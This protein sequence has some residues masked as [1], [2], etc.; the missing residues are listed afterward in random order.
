MWIIEGTTQRQRIIN[1][2][3]TL[4]SNS[5]GRFQQ[6]KLNNDLANVKNQY[7]QLLTELGK[8]AWEQQ[9]IHPSYVHMFEILGNFFQERTRLQSEL[10]A[11][12]TQLQRQNNQHTQI[13]ADYA[14][15]IKAV[16]DQQKITNNRLNQMRSA[17]QAS[18]KQLRQIALE[19]QKIHTEIQT[20]QQRLTL[21]ANTTAPDRESQITTFNGAIAALEQKLIALQG[22]SQSIQTEISR[23]HGEQVALMSEV[24]V[25]DQ[26]ITQLQAELRQ[27]L[28]PIERQS[29]EFKQQQRQQNETISS[30]MRQIESSISELGIQVAQAHPSH[31]NL[32]PLYARMEQLQQQIR[33]YSNQI[34]LLRARQATGDGSAVRTVVLLVVVLLGS[35]S[36]IVWTIVNRVLL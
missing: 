4:F 34:D 24:T 10:G 33:E 6:I 36:V 8:R 11:L 32:D 1:A 15:R 12:E 19:E 16:Q 22:Q 17:N 27:V 2:C 3:A 18:E 20:M 14:G 35:I 5:K 28:D 25:F 21:L 29:E 13:K 7:G 30:I 31:T 9:I 23:V 26:Q